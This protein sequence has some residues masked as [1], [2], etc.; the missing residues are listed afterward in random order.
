MLSV[1]C[2]IRMNKS[3]NNEMIMHFG[4][5][6]KK[7]ILYQL[8]VLIFFLFIIR[9]AVAQSTEHSAL[10]WSARVQDSPGKTLPCTLMA[11]SACKIHRGCNVL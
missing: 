7:C 4:N 6:P 2:E 11:P 8:S 10:D 1:E 5:W 3:I 9:S